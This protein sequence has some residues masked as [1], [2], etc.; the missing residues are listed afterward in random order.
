M[1]NKLKLTQQLVAQLPEQY[2]TTVDAA[3]ISWWFNVGNR[4]GLRLTAAG[5][6]VLSSY[7]D[8]EYHE[9]KISDTM[10]FTMQ[11]VLDL[12]RRLQQP[13]YIT[14]KK[15]QAISILFFGSKEAVLANLYGNIEKFLD[16]YRP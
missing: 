4:G 6:K 3:R 13:Y 8:L 10:S 16:N 1:R 15:G 14:T 9:Y 5:F 11:T 7:L 2:A 12:D